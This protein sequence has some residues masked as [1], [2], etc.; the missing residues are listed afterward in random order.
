MHGVLTTPWAVLL[1]FKTILNLLLVLEAEVIR[2]LALGVRA[3][4]FYEGIL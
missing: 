1:Q 2:A 3:L 4:K